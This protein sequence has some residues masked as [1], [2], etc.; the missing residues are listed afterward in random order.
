MKWYWSPKSDKAMEKT[1]RELLQQD[2]ARKL[3][4]IEDGS[5]NLNEAGLSDLAFGCRL[6]FGRWPTDAEIELFRAAPPRDADSL[7]ARFYSSPE[8][9]ARSLAV[10]YERP[11]H[12]CLVMTE[13]PEGLRF[14]FSLRDTFVG[15]PIAVGVF[16]RDVDA[17]FQRLLRPGMNCLDIGANLGYYSIRMGAVVSQGGGRVYSFEP[18]PFAFSLLT[19][20][21]QENRLENVISIFQV[22]CGAEE[23]IGVVIQDPNPAN[24]GGGYVRELG[25]ENKAAGSSISIRRIDDLVPA[26]VRIDLVKIDIEGFEPF[27]LRG[28]DR[29]LSRDRPAIV[30]EFNPPA[31]RFSGADA[32]ERLLRHLNAHG[33]VCF[34]ALSYSRGESVPFRCGGAAGDSLVNLVCLPSAKSS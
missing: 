2:F 29:V 13:T 14:F 31:L 26:D 7:A 8:F 1:S 24:Y 3:R 25:P 30:M 22:A 28:M 10:A 27:A 9:R 32:P 18:D 16:E 4:D 17:A 20:N 11:G 33:Y 5:C 15:I 19:K 34:E 23:A 6:L 21:R 12:D